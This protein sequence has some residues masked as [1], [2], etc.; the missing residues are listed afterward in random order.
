MTA[1]RRALLLFASLLPFGDR[2]AAA[3][4]AAADRLAAI[5]AMVLD[6]AVRFSVQAVLDELNAIEPLTAPGGP[7][8]G[9]V[10][11]LRSFLEDK[12]ERAEDSIRHG[13]EAL[14]IEA[15]H[16]FLDLGDKV[17]LQY[18][19]ARQAERLGRCDAAIPHYR[20]VLP[21][22]APNG[23]GQAGQ[24]GTRQRLAFCLHE[25]G[26]FAEARTI[27]RAI[28]AEATALFSRDDPR[29]FTARL[30]LAQNDY[31]L[32]DAAAARTVLEGL[33]AD[34]LR[35]DDGDM[36]DRSLFQLGVLAFEGGRGSEALAFMERRLSLAQA[37]GDPA[38]TAAA[39][40]ALDVLHDK[41]SA[42]GN[43]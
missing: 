11:Q 42:A 15:V 26:Q 22:L 31:A 16:P 18:S 13:E 37:S 40:E 27:N 10:M 3:D 41:L 38:R 5:H 9:R 30:N 33:L 29:T 6:P 32:G 17:S 8:R 1:L 20:A 14:R 25:V 4:G 23:V 35:A 43:P 28:L 2:V 7:E 36:T 39:R 12:G 34:A 24:L 19:V 21:L